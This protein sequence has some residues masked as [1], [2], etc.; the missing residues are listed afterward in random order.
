VIDPR[1]LA[2]IHIATLGPTFVIGNFAGTALLCLSLGAFILWRADS[3]QQFAF[4]FYFVSL[5]I[6]YVPM[7]FYALGITNRDSARAEIVD[8]L[9]KKRGAVANYGRQSIYLLLP[10]MVPIVALQRRYKPGRSP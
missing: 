9:N 10:L 7:L 2:A 6:N 8:E 4:G 5:G 3:C 1:K